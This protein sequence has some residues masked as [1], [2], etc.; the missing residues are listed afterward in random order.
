MPVAD[1]ARAMQLLANLQAFAQQNND[2]EM[3]TLTTQLRDAITKRNS[4]AM[5]DAHNPATAFDGI[6]SLYIGLN[7]LELS[8][9]A[10]NQLN[11][12]EAPVQ[13]PDD[14]GFGENLSLDEMGSAVASPTGGG[15]SRVG[16]CAPLILVS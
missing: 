5:L 11:L 2:P 1:A 4:P 7:G 16:T 12:A 6:T 8:K 15:G 14:L 10:L 13:K 9:A 3:K